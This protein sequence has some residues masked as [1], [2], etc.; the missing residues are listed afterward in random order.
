MFVVVLFVLISVSLLFTFSS[1]S[2][3]QFP[4]VCHFPI[5]AP[6][7]L[8]SSV[9]LPRLPA[10]F[11]LALFTHFLQVAVTFRQ[12]KLNQ[13]PCLAWINK[14]RG[15]S[16]NMRIHKELMGSWEWNP[17]IHSYRRLS[18]VLYACQFLCVC[19]G[20]GVVKQTTKPLRKEMHNH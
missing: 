9:S 4:S 5:L 20:G 6:F 10:A 19:C 12:H 11:P 14:T 16:I 13:K 15:P 17:I 8:H 1:L 3:S 18:G 2:L 7:I